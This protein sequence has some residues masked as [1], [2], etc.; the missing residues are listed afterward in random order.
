MNGTYEP[1]ELA[2]LVYHLHGSDEHINSL[3]LTEDDYIDFLVNVSREQEILPPRIHEALTTACLLFIGYRLKD[4]NFRVIHRG[5][6]ESMDLGQRELS[7]TVQITPPDGHHGDPRS[8][9]EF[10][11]AY[12]G[13]MKVR[14]FWGTA[15]EFATELRRRWMEFCK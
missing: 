1:S 7:I 15:A 3:V 14:V 6:V 12:F 13:N 2:P 11:N 8:A 4:I 5:L 10:L 9:Q